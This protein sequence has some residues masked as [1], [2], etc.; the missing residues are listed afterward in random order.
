MQIIS[1]WCFVSDHYY[2]VTLCNCYVIATLT[3][4]IIISF[5]FP[6]RGIYDVDFHRKILENINH[7]EVK[8]L[9]VPNIINQLI[10]RHNKIWEI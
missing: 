9:Q 3:V 6:F 10:I 8:K 7:L 4:I 1:N 5:R 2:C